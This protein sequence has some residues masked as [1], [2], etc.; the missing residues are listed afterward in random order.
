MQESR[1]YAV[2]ISRQELIAA[3]KAYFPESMM[4]KRLSN[5]NLTM[6]VMGTN[7]GLNIMWHEDTDASVKPGQLRITDGV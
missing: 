2:T 5:A 6:A 3:V 7:A 4:V 1:K